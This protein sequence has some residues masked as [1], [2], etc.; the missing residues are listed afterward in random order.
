MSLSLVNA[1]NFD[2]PSGY[3]QKSSSVSMTELEN[4]VGDYIIIADGDLYK[5]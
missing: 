3:Q 4:D 5:L 2:I 1:V